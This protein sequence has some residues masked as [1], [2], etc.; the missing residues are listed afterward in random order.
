MLG[1]VKTF[2]LR[3]GKYKDRSTTLE[4]LSGITMLTCLLN[5]HMKAL[6]HHGFFIRHTINLYLTNYGQNVHLWTF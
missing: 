2:K 5:C 1:C 3:L 6:D 4:A